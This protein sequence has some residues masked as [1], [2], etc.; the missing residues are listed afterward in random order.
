[1]NKY[2]IMLIVD[3]AIDI[4]MANEIV[5][6]VFDKKNIN[7]AVKLENTTL[8]YPINKSTKAQYIVYTLEAKSELI[9][10]FTRRANIAKFIWRQMVINLDTEKGFQKS[11]KAFKHRIAKD[12]K[13]VNKG[14]SVKQLIENLEKT[15][16]HK[17]KPN[18]K[19]EVKKS[20]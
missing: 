20:N 18:F 10:E 11:K 5:E 9:A 17:T 4:A 19:K 6:S 14:T 3:P 13:V 12:A 15:I 1:M 16:S 2:E 7:K 8:A